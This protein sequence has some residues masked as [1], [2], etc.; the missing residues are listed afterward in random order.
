MD[1]DVNSA[2]TIQN[3]TLKQSGD[4]W[5]DRMN[6]AAGATFVK[7]SVAVIGQSAASAIVKSAAATG[8]KLQYFND[9]NHEIQNA[10]VK[11]EA[12][13]AREL[14]SQLTHSTVENA[15]SG[16][17]T[18]SNTA[19]S[20]SGV[21]ASGGD[22]TLMNLAAAT[23]V[24]LLEIA[25]GKTV[26]ACVGSNSDSKAAL[27][28]TG[29]ALLCGGSTLN[30]ASLTLADGATLDMENLAGGAVMNGALTFAGKVQAGNKLLSILS[31]LNEWEE[32]Q[33][34]ITGLSKVTLAD[35]DM[36]EG[37]R[38]LASSVFSDVRNS[39]LHMEFQMVGDV[40]A[41]LVINVPEPATSTLGLL[42]L[43]ALAARRR[44]R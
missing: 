44:R 32:S 39:T 7:D 1:S 8:D 15:G 36:T 31:E 5:F 42:A 3:G 43:A 18:V 19:N 26:N 30:A 4:M 10:W 21:V 37:Q 6:V 33:V 17:L 20:L 16:H 13:E 41:L 2:L 23:S 40:G 9:G 34:L 25:A 22:M 29:S 14:K 27:T 38:V 12:A 35:V 28:V 11:V 24:D